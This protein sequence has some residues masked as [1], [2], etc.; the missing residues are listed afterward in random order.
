LAV[1]RALLF[2]ADKELALTNIPVH[3]GTLR[4]EAWIYVNGKLAGE[5]HNDTS[6]TFNVREFLRAGI[7]TIAVL[8]KCN[9]TSGGRGHTAVGDRRGLDGHREGNPRR[10]RGNDRPSFE[11][12]KFFLTIAVSG[13][14]AALLF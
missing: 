7:N 12:I 10:S 2:V 4:D 1:F 11:P 14:L 8:V 9:G 3:F 6:P 13:W 5:S